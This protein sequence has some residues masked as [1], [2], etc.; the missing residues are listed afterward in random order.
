MKPETIVDAIMD[1][2]PALGD[3]NTARQALSRLLE[4]QALHMGHSDMLYCIL[5]TLDEAHSRGQEVFGVLWEFRQTLK[6]GPEA[7]KEVA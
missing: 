3:F 2:E 5:N 4:D 7:P 6:T 1:L